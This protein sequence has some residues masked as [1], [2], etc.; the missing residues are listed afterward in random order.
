[1][2]NR[3]YQLWKQALQMAYSYGNENND[4]SHQYSKKINY[5]P[6]T[7]YQISN[8]VLWTGDRQHYNLCTIWTLAQNHLYKDYFQKAFDMVHNRKFLNEQN[9][10]CI[11]GKLL[12]LSESFLFDRQHS[13][14]GGESSYGSV[15]SGIPQ[16]SIIRPLLFTMEY[17]NDILDNISFFLLM[18]LRS[19]ERLRSRTSWRRESSRSVIDGPRS[20]I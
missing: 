18:I 12:R 4:T 17:I 8:S 3:L 20:Q 10:F 2:V 13:V 14:N 19:L 11:R 7:C 5:R 1:M 6:I 9:Y 15:L 16:G